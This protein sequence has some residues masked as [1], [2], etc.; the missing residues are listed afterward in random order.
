MAYIA[1]T[2]GFGA[3]KTT[4]LCM[5]KKL[6]ASIIDVDKVVHKILKRQDT[7]KQ[8][9]A[10]LGEDV[11]KRSSRGVSLDKRR[12]ADK[13]FDDPQKRRSI[14]RIIHPLVLEEIKRISSERKRRRPLTIFEIP[15]LFEAGFER[16]FDY[17]IAVYCDRKTVIK[18]LLKKGFTE[19]EALK[20]I[21]AQWPVERKVLLADFVIDNSNGMRKTEKQTRKIYNEITSTLH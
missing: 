4:V 16:H 18:R 20:R 3:G 2:G 14:E 13:I 12:I 19:S 9:T 11:I 17:T 21:R 10:L 1:L 6:G 15:L 7:I 8:I 5:F